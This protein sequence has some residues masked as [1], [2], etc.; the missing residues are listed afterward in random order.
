[1]TRTTT[2]WRRALDRAQGA[3][4]KGSYDQAFRLAR[5]VI[6]GTARE[7]PGAPKRACASSAP[8][9]ASSTTASPP[10]PREARQ[11][12]DRELLTYVCKRNGITLP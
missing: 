4:L 2:T 6:D 3:Y 7:R 5:H 1:M 11:Q 9:A 12:E 10:P 8:R